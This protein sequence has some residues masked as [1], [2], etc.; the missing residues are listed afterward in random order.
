M[1]YC[2]IGF[3]T[4]SFHSFRFSRVLS[5]IKGADIAVGGGSNAEDKFIEPTILVNVKPTDPVMQDEIFGPVLPIV[6]IS[7]A[8]EAIKFIN[9]R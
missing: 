5:L 2:S 8:F 9:E 7:N 3:V 4:I 1:I 6:N